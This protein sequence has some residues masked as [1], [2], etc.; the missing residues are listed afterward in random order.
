MYRNLTFEN[1]ELQSN[2]K[3]QWVIPYKEI[4]SVLKESCWDLECILVSISE[5]RFSEQQTDLKLFKFVRSLIRL[6]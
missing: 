3:N 2:C 4:V 5:K 1:S 6:V